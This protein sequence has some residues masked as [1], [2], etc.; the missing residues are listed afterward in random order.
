MKNTIKLSCLLFITCLSLTSYSSDSGFGFIES[1]SSVDSSEGFKKKSYGKEIDDLGVETLDQLESDFRINVG[2]TGKLKI[3]VDKDLAKSKDV[4]AV[5]IVLKF[6]RPIIGK[7][8]K[9]NLVVEDFRETRSGGFYLRFK[10]VVNGAV[11][12]FGG[13]FYVDKDDNVVDVQV[14]LIDTDYYNVDMDNWLPMADLIQ[15]AHDK[16]QAVL[17]PVEIDENSRGYSKYITYRE[18]KSGDVVPMLVVGYQAR[19]V[20]VNVL[21]GIT[22]IIN[23]GSF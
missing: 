13:S 21:N 2:V 8:K 3:K 5:F 17:G 1:S 14:S 12:N 15:L 6:M 11:T 10:Q 7:I 18:L 23:A 19:M 9:K 16:L 22:G 20:R 4:K